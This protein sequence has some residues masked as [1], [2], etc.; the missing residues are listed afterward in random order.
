MLEFVLGDGRA[1]KAGLPALTER[2]EVGSVKD[3]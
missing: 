2:T 3:L 1:G